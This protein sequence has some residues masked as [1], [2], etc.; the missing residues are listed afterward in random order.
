MKKFKKQ[1]IKVALTIEP[2]F[3][4]IKAFVLKDFGYHK[5]LSS[6]YYN[7]THIPSGIGVMG[8]YYQKIPTAKQARV[9]TEKLASIK[10]TWKP[11]KPGWKN[12]GEAP[13]NYP[14]KWVEILKT[15]ILNF[16]D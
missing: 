4:E 8:D 2:F 3:K 10:E 15:T 7:I 14:K 9:L 5:S 16:E 11:K 12:K 1:T 6:N 13:K